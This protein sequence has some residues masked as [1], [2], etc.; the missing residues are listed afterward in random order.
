MTPFLEPLI[1]LNTFFLTH[2]NS[3][4]LLIK[5]WYQEQNLAQYPKRKLARKNYRQYEFLTI[6]WLKSKLS[7]KKK[8]WLPY[9]QFLIKSACLRAFAL[10]LLSVHKA[11]L[12]D[13][14]VA[15]SSLHSI[16]MSSPQLSPRKQGP[17]LTL[18]P[19]ERLCYFL[20]GLSSPDM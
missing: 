7:F 3:S 11:Y 12:S 10:A 17:S 16:H 6:L 4:V 15:S 1:I 5:M 18:L 20:M 13:I 14:H 19:P 9:W 2:S 8:I